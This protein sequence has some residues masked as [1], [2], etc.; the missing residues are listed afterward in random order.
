MHRIQ[1]ESEQTGIGRDANK[2][3]PKGERVPWGI[4]AGSR[5]TK[6]SQIACAPGASRRKDIGCF[7][8]LRISDKKRDGGFIQPLPPRSGFDCPLDVH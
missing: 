2:V 5:G 3:S 6:A 4:Y 8:V 1:A 7:L